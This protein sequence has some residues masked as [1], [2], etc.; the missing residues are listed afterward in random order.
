MIIAENS[1]S[2]T[3]VPYSEI[4]FKVVES[5]HLNV[6]VPNWCTPVG[7]SWLYMNKDGGPDRRYNN[8]VQIPHYK[9]WEL[10]FSFPSGRIDTAFADEKALDQFTDALDRLIALSSKRKVVA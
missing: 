2:C 5:T 8:N 7:Y 3:F 4:S 1:G 6:P 9:V 10:D